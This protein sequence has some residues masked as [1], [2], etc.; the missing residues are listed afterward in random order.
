MSKSVKEMINENLSKRQSSAHIFEKTIPIIL[1]LCAVISIIT[2]FGIILIL[3]KE[4]VSFFS[5]VS[6]VEFLT[7]K[8]WFPFFENDPDYGIWPLVAG[9]LLITVVAMLV[10]IPIGLASAIYSREDQSR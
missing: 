3:L 2:T 6:F 5:N 10:A 8:E 9:T 7:S 4:T 1:L